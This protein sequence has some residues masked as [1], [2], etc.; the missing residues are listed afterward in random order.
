MSGV[1]AMDLG[2]CFIDN[3][4]PVQISREVQMNNFRMKT[5]PIEWRTA[6]GRE[7]MEASQLSC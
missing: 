7:K 1:N 4:K 2:L 3:T 5:I 6:W